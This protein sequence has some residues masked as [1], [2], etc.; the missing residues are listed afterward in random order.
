MSWTAATRSLLLRNVSADRVTYQ[1]Y[2]LIFGA[3]F[4][5]GTV[6]L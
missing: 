6:L 4:A 3:T 5:C 2:C 1:M